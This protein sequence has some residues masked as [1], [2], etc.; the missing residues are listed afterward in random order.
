MEEQ[1]NDGHHLLKSIGLSM[2][3]ALVVSNIIGSG[4][5]KK[6]APM[7]EGLLDPMYVLFAWVLAGIIVLF[8][9]MSVA[10]L[11]AMYPHSGGPFSWLRNIY[12][13]IF[14]YLYGW[15]TFAIIQTATIASIAFVFAG[16]LGSFIPLPELSD[17]LRDVTL[18]GL[19][20][21][22]NFGG[23]IVAVALIWLLTF[24]N[25]R[26]AKMGGSVSQ[27]FIYA[28]VLGILAIVAACLFSGAGSMENLSARSVNF[29]A[30]GLNRWS[31]FLGA[32]LLS[33]QSAFWAYEGW[34]SLGFLGEEIKNPEKNLPKALIIGFLIIIAIYLVVNFSYL[35]VMPV[36]DIIAGTQ[37]DENAIAAVLVMQKAVGPSAA[38][39][40]AGLILLSTFG[41]TNTTILGSARIYYAMARKGE[42]FSAIGKTH[43]VY[44][45]PNNALLL[46]AVWSS[47]LVFSGSF[48]SLTDLL[49]FAAF[50]YYGSVVLGVVVLRIKQPDLPR[51]YKTLGYPVVPLVFA[52][53]SFCFVGYAIYDAPQQ[54]AI[55]LAL[56]LLGLPL[57]YFVF[58]KKA[59]GNK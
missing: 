16:A 30:S 2:A 33:M 38:L 27:V 55:G 42:F 3:I 11:A 23:K 49:I 5:F 45:T 32:I 12:G 9:V 35:Y 26:G 46:Q 48:D 52:L 1:N 53:F 51:P 4:I 58:K 29:E 22:D 57:Y 47:V 59:L 13:N 31:V 17:G 25:M 14:G 56:I 36:D 41:C 54:S 43:P 19:H 37:A 39:I 7:S 40:V 28:V 21:F 8:G 6:V 10:E 24:I 15:S 34:I 18:F 44:K 20:P 50:I